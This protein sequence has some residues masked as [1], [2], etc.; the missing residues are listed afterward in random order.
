M[1]HIEKGS[2]TWHAVKTWATE[3]LEI[4]RGKCEEP[5]LPSIETEA[6]RA[7]VQTLRELLKLAED[8]PHIP[9]PGPNYA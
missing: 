5:G 7:R 2:D 4:A 8:K 3:E 9:D 6:A 1:A